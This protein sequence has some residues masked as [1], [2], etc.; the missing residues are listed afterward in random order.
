MG[1]AAHTTGWKVD[2]GFHDVTEGRVHCSVK[3]GSEVIKVKSAETARLISAA[4]DLL[5]VAIKSHEPYEGLSDQDVIDLYGGREAELCLALRAAI[6]KVVASEA[7][8]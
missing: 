4:P 6:A 1:E 5:A 3:T 7:V 2:T 8:Q